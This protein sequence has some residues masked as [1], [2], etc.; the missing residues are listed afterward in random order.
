MPQMRAQRMSIE[1]ENIKQEKTKQNRRESIKS[2]LT[3]LCHM[4]TQ[5]GFSLHLTLVSW[6]LRA[7]QNNN[8]LMTFRAV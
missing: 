1:A 8:T 6:P 2:S 3:R 5:L 4:S 7:M